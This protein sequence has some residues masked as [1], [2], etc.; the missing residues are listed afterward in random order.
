MFKYEKSLYGIIK[1]LKFRYFYI[2]CQVPGSNKI[3]KFQPHIFNGYG[4]IEI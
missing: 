1:V 4:V 2:Y 3:P